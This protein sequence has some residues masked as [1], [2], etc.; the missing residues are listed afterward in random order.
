MLEHW[1]LFMKVWIIE[2]IL[3][4]SNSRTYLWKCKQPNLSFN[5][6]KVEHVLETLNSQ[7]YPGMFEQLNVSLRVQA[8]G[9]FLKIWPRSLSK[10]WTSKLVLEALNSRAC[11]KFN[12]PSNLSLKALMVE[13][14]HK[15]W[16][17]RTCPWNFKH[18]TSFLKFKYPTTLSKIWTFE[19]SIES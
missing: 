2:L 19:P 11:H 17:S 5:V 3:E 12:Y 9:F 15:N 13:L 8:D 7:N 10:I 16:I 4:I 18:L 14:I 1:N 6:W